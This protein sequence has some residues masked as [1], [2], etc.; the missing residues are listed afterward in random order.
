MSSEDKDKYAKLLGIPLLDFE[1]ELQTDESPK[2][3]YNRLAGEIANATRL[4]TTIQKI[5]G[6]RSGTTTRQ[7]LLDRRLKKHIQGIIDEKDSSKHSIGVN[8]F[9]DKVTGRYASNEVIRK[10]LSDLQIP[11]TKT[12]GQLA[13][14]AATKR[15]AA[16]KG[17]TTQAASESKS[18]SS[19]SSAAASKFSSSTSTTASGAQS[20]PTTPKQASSSSSSSASSAAASSASS[21]VIPYSDLDDY[22]FLQLLSEADLLQV[23]TPEV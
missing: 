18:S 16:Q 2:Q 8:Y 1:S 9:K 4:G 11:S 10:A 3:T 6:N 23:K 19:S 5:N 21:A 17:A 22:D 7:Q 12:P 14:E 13:V 20:K 15:A